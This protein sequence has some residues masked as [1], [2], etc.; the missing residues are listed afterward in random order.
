[1]TALSF[2]PPDTAARP[3]TLLD[4]DGFDAW[5]GGLSPAAAAWV[6]AQGFTAAHGTAVVL[7]GPDG[8]PSAAAVGLGTARDRARN[9]FALAKAR[10]SLPEG[11]WRLEHG[12]PPDDLSA[13][14]LGWLLDGYRFGRYREATPPK[15]MLV[16]PDGVDAARLEAIAAAEALTRDLINT[17]AERHGSGRACQPRPGRSPPNT[18]RRSRE[19]VGD[20]LLAQNF[21]LIHTVGARRVRAPRLIDLRW[22]DAGPTLTLVGKGVCFDTGGLNLKPGAVDGPDEE[23]HGRRRDGPWASRR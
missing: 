6:D 18:A 10:S 19:I 7:P 9:R 23:G 12:L 21:P 1:M 4:K 8:Q 22:G 5:K 20:D 2:A 17:P 14:C 3:L 13:E 15:A 11:T 16:A